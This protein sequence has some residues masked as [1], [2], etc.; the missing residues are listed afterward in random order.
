[1]GNYF[2]NLGST[3]ST[4]AAQFEANE[5][6]EAAAKATAEA[7]EAN[8]RAAEAYRSI[9]AEG[10]ENVEDAFG[11]SKRLV[12]TL[13]RMENMSEARTVLQ[14][15]AKQ[16]P[17]D[18]EVLILSAAI[19]ERT[20]DTREAQRI[21]AS[22]VEKHPSSHLP[23]YRRA[24]L[25]RDDPAMFPDVIQ[26]LDQVLRLRPDMMDAWGLKFELYKSRGRLEEALVELRKG[27]ENASGSNA[28]TLRRK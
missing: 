9:I 4:E 3:K 6:P 19:A 27:L 13:I 17:N 11:V 24:V 23:Y 15:A 21:L 14:K 18:L 8:R 5:Q 12:E 22:A 10:G 16:Y 7:D 20:G 1:M 2:F 26:D 25:N 28:D